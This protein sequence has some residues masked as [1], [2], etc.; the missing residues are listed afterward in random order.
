MHSMNGALT[1]FTDNS[2]FRADVSL[3][4]V[5]NYADLFSGPADWCAHCQTWVSM[6]TRGV[7]WLETEA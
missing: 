7:R 4:R 6:A 2:L 1:S 5:V 3:T